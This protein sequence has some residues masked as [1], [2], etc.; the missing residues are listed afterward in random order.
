MER[1]KFANI[2]AEAFSALI[3]LDHRIGL[4]YDRR[5]I[6]LSRRALVTKSLWGYLKSMNPDLMRNR[7][8]FGFLR[9]RSSGRLKVFIYRWYFL[10]S[11]RPLNIDDFVND[12]RCLSESEL[13]PLLEFDTIYYYYM[14]DMQ[15]ESSCQG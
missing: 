14:D 1:H 8:M 10:I 11:S 3:R 13:P 9:K 6:E 5:N 4:N 15:D 2:D 12:E 7:V